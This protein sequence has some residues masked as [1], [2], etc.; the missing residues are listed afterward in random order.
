MTDTPVFANA[1]QIVAWFASLRPLQRLELIARVEQ[2]HAH[3]RGLVL[4][5]KAV[6]AARVSDVVEAERI[7]ALELFYSALLPLLQA[8]HLIRRSAALTNTE[9]ATLER[10]KAKVRE[11]LL[12]LE[13]LMQEGFWVPLKQRWQTRIHAIEPRTAPI[14]A[15]DPIERLEQR[16]DAER[17]KSAAVYDTARALALVELVPDRGEPVNPLELDPD[18]IIRV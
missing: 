12:Y 8:E 2:R 3:Y 13:P 4:T 14:T 11:E 1:R 17:A 7:L 10:H 6:H 15:T 9:R 5:V 16:L 18:P